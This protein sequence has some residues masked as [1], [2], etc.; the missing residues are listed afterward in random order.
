MKG[1][2]SEFGVGA[3]GHS[4]DPRLKSQKSKGVATY[5]YKASIVNDEM[6]KMNRAGAVFPPP[7]PTD[8]GKGIKL[9][10]PAF[11]KYKEYIYTVKL[12]AYG[13]KTL[14]EALYSRITAKDYQANQ[15]YVVHPTD[16][17][18]GLKGF[19]RFPE[20]RKII[21]DYKHAAKEEFRKD[22]SNE[23]RMEVT[24]IENR[25]RE[26]E[27]IEENTRRTQIS[28]EGDGS[29]ELNA[30]DFAASINR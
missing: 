29:M 14:T 27:R 5:E 4:F 28:L 6:I 17:T 10:P 19:K 8:F 11:R 18:D 3:K 1:A 12:P 25:Q 23:Y 21:N 7:R 9:S 16:G 15:D 2:V 20:L 22:G 13:G 24:L 26:S 30:Q